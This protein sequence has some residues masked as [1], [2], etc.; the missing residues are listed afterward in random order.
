MASATTVTRRGNNASRQ[1]VIS[2]TALPQ[3]S[4]HFAH[5]SRIW[6]PTQGWCRVPSVVQGGRN[7]RAE[8][9]LITTHSCMILKTI[10]RPCQNAHR[11]RARTPRPRTCADPKDDTVLTWEYSQSGADSAA[12][13]QHEMCLGTERFQDW[14]AQSADHGRP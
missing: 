6:L 5:H 2:F 4:L 1:Q 9:V 10:G 8:T 12:T 11:A 7:T 13:N 3:S 14:K